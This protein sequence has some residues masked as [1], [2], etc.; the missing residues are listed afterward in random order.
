MRQ[1]WRNI[2]ALLL[3]LVFPPSSVLAAMPV[4]WCIGADGHRA[5]EISIG[6]G[7][8]HVDHRA[9]GGD[10]TT[11]ED[12]DTQPVD[13]S[14]QDRQLLDKSKVCAAGDDGI[15]AFDLRAYVV[16]PSVPLERAD[17]ATQ[18]H[19]PEAATAPPDALHVARR[20]VVLLI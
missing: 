15:V 13:D 11:L 6:V 5:V 2:V 20:T 1:R 4:V 14:C 16:L 9:L 10:R 3:I 8:K 19:Y 17:G 7:A 12:A 18:N